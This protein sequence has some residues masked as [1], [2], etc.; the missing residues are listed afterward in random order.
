MKHNKITFIYAHN[1]FTFHLGPPSTYILLSLDSCTNYS[2]GRR[3]RGA[4]LHL[5]V[6]CQLLSA[7]LL[8]FHSFVFVASFFNYKTAASLFLYHPPPLS[9][10]LSRSLSSSW[11]IPIGSKLSVRQGNRVLKISAPA[12]SFLTSHASLPCCCRP[13][14]H[15]NASRLTQ[16]TAKCKYTPTPPLYQQKIYKTFLIIQKKKKQGE[17]QKKNERRKR[18]ISPFKAQ[19]SRKRNA[20]CFQLFSAETTTTTALGGGEG[21]IGEARGI[22]E[23]KSA[24]RREELK[25][26]GHIPQL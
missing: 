16:P 18:K 17:P 23:R 2:H 25:N 20:H 6:P 4:K 7:L 24:T 19:Q 13:R 8:G 14:L 3:A 15:S 11:G 5:L 12:A 22:E 10:S 1:N 21:E 9:L 26:F